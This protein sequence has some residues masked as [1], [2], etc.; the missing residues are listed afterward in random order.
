MHLIFLIFFYFFA[1]FESNES[2]LKALRVLRGNRVDAYGISLRGLPDALCH[3]YHELFRAS[4]MNL[5]NTDVIPLF[6][7]T[8]Q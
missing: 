3:S 4:I 8:A 2:K 7:G 5:G 1:Q 6:T